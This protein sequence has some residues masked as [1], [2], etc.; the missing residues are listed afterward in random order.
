[1]R[2]FSK[3]IS[4]MNHH[5]QSITKPN[6]PCT[7]QQLVSIPQIQTAILQSTGYHAPRVVFGFGPRQVVEA[8][9]KHSVSIARVVAFLQRVEQPDA[10]P[11]SV[12]ILPTGCSSS[13]ASSRPS[14]RSQI[15]RHVSFEKLT[16]TA[17]ARVPV[18]TNGEAGP[19]DQA[20]VAVRGISL[21]RT[22]LV[23]RG[24]I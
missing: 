24:E 7:A 19:G 4:P 11:E 5:S 3:A 9:G 2:H 23:D 16:S 12:V 13:L 21:S 22:M 10:Y 18:A 15:S 14:P 17:P 8:R 1:M 6:K 20:K